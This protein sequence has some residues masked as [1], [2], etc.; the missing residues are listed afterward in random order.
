MSAKHFFNPEQQERII[1]AIREA[2][3]NTSGEIRLHIEDKCKQDAVHRATELFKKLKMHNTELRN[4]VLFYLAVKSNHFALVGDKG[5][6]EK[7]TDAFW[8]TIRDKTIANFKKGNFTEGLCEAIL[9]C[10][11]QLKTHFPH[12]NDDKNE[13]SDD[14]S[15]K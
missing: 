9:E 7:V 4:G 2:E 1:G 5:I 8:E 12:Q 14:I 13:L 15:Y 6:H 3:K 10:G 11:Q